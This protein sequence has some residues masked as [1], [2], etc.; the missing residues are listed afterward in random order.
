MKRWNK[1]IFHHFWR[2]IIKANIKILFRRWEF[3]FDKNW[4]KLDY[5]TIFLTIIKTIL[6]KT[7][8]WNL[9]SNLVKIENYLV[10]RK[11]R[12]LSTM[13]QSLNLCKSKLFLSLQ[14]GAATTNQSK[15][16]VRRIFLWQHKNYDIFE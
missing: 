11:R 1:S 7:L 2:A 9:E 10:W 5:Q 3:D 16:P 14:G 13:K 6:L 15:S 12:F 4:V 8:L